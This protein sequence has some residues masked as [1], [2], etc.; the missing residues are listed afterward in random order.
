MMS[1]RDFQARTSRLGT[2]TTKLKAIDQALA[3][4][5]QLPI[6]QFTDRRKQ[7]RVI[8]GAA[9]D[10]LDNSSKHAHD[11]AVNTLVTEVGTETDGIP[12]AD[13]MKELVRQAEGG[14]EVVRSL[15]EAETAA[16]P[17]E[18]IRALLLAQELVLEQLTSRGGFGSEIDLDNTNVFLQDRVTAA[19]NRLSDADKETIVKDDLGRLRT[20][21]SDGGA[22]QITRD[23]LGDLLAYEDITKFTTGN[24]GTTLSPEGTDEKY[25]TKHTIRQA[26]GATERLGSLAHELTHV[27]AGEAYGNSDI[28]LLFSPSLTDEEVKS[29]TAERLATIE[30]LRGLLA[31][32]GALNAD[33]Q[34]LVKFKLDYATD[35][36]KGVLVYADN[37]LMAKKI[38]QAQY[39]RLKHIDELSAP[40]SSVLVE[41][42]PIF[43]QILVYLH[44]WGVDQADPFYDAVMREATRLRTERHPSR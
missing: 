2:R 1:V 38:D 10:Y 44:Q 42:D 41:Y 5:Y 16:N 28:L 20:I 18:E 40:H 31:A 30:R 21:Q 39:E 17:L 35:R 3:A 7:L 8:R 12:A 24:A 22:P 26:H 23:I 27:D 9:Q 25:T 14:V 4:Y 34:G 11:D 43:T 32:S 33:Q 19:V 29:L 36:R 13:V 15:E 6:L 37:Y